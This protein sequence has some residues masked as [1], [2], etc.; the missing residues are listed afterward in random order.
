MRRPR[1]AEAV[2]GRRWTD[3]PLRLC[4]S[5]DG[6]RVDCARTAEL[7]AGMTPVSVLAGVGIGPDQ[8]VRL[9][10]ALNVSAESFFAG[11]V[12]ADAGAL[13]AAAEQSVEDGADILDIGA[14]STAA[15]PAAP[16]ELPAR[17]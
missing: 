4:R 6:Q 3:G 14:R 10:A 15:G 2:R 5:D 11:S 13:R 7:S 8:P 17:I 9:M 16:E 12:H 1:A